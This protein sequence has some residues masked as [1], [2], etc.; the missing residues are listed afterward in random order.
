M[1]VHLQIGDIVRHKKFGSGTV[2][3]VDKGFCTVSFK[4]REAMFRLPEAFEEG[5]LTSDKVVLTEEDAEEE[6]LQMAEDP[7]IPA[8][9]EDKKHQAP[10]WACYVMAIIMGVI[11]IPIAIVLF[12]SEVD[13]FIY[14]GVLFC[15][16]PVV[17]FFAGYLVKPSS[18]EST[19][20]SDSSNPSTTYTPPV[21][22]KGK[23]L[24]ESDTDKVQ[25]DV[26]DQQKE[27]LSIL[28]DM[29]QMHSVN[30]DADLEEHYGWDYKIDYDQDGKDL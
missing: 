21:R 5:F 10:T 25:Q 13:L 24:F 17:G 9:K 14:L 30:P 8:P 11:F 29:V 3:A 27:S 12:Q 26:Y 28:E 1:E 15:F 6:G 4:S 20:Y 18:S 16:A 2:T 22:K 19:V 23:G 7:E